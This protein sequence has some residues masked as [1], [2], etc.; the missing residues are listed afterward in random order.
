MS[1][2]DPE[3]EHR[4]GDD[5]R[6]GDVAASPVRSPRERRMRSAARAASTNATIVPMSGMTMLTI[7]HTSAAI[8]NGS[9]RGAAPQPPAP[10]AAPAPGGLGLG[11]DRHRAG[12]VGIPGGSEPRAAPKRT[13]GAHYRHARSTRSVSPR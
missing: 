2:D 10:P 11:P 5:A 12:V 9:I 13:S 1:A 8:A 3:R 7:A 6:R 4:T